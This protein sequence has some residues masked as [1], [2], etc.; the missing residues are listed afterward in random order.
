MNTQVTYSSIGTIHSPF[1]DT[2]GMPIQP[3]GAKGVKGT[4]DIDPQFENGLK[5]LE[6]FSHIILIYHFHLSTGYSLEVK[7]FL[8]DVLRGVFSTRA[9]RRPNA[10]GISAVRLTR[11]EGCTLHVEDLDVVDGTPLLDVKPYIPE[12]DAAEAE[13]IGWFSEK[14]S[15]VSKVK[16]DDRFR[17]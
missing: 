8:D 17:R 16:S 2:A 10:I 12:I 3:T 11:V 4:I 14:V 7:P 9:P 5:D 15:G 6:G 1:P 13:R